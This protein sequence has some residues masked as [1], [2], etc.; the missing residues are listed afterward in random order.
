LEPHKLCQSI[1][2]AANAFNAFYEHCPCVQAGYADPLRLEL[3]ERFARVMA[4][5]ILCLGI[6]PLESMPRGPKPAARSLS[7]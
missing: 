3:M 1:Y 4:S 7:L 5:A 2:S 6:Q